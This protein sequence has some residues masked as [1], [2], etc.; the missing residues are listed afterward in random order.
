MK[1]YLFAFN[2]YIIAWDW[3][4]CK[5]STKI[6]RPMYTLGTIQCGNYCRR[7]AEHWE[8]VKLLVVLK[9]F[10]KCNEKRGFVSMDDR[11]IPSISKVRSKT[12]SICENSHV[13][14]I[15]YVT[16][17]EKRKSRQDL[18]V[19]L[20]VCRPIKKSRNIIFGSAP[21][22]IWLPTYYAA[23]YRNRHPQCSC[24]KK[25]GLSQY[26]KPRSSLDSRIIFFQSCSLILKIIHLLI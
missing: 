24:S 3:R 15:S 16:S 19:L 9:G 20:W 23:A 8:L 22:Q 12:L 1:F 18:W 4:L 7:M 5:S 17:S 21:L 25:I 6:D 14:E 2:Q 13:R 10:I 11:D 26:K